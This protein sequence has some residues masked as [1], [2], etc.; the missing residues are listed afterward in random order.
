MLTIINSNTD[1]RFNLAVEEYVLKYLNLEEDF[2]LI[3][4]NDKS[5][6]IGRNQNPFIEINGA[7]VNKNHIP[8]IRR[9]TDRGAIYHDEGSIN[10]A[11]VTAST[12]KNNGNHQEFLDP[13]VTVLKGMGIDAHIKNK[14]NLFV[15]KD[16]ISIDYQNTYNDKIIHHGIIFVDSN[17]SY[18]KLVHNKKKINVVNVKKYFK[19]R[20]TVSM[21]RVLLLHELLEGEVAR[22]VY[23]LDKLDLKRINQLVEK[24]YNNWDWNYGESGEF[25]VKKEYDNRI[26]ITL[27]IKRGFIKDVSI[28]SFENPIKLEKA[29]LNIKYNEEEIR[30]AISSFTEIDTQEMIDTIMY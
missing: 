23:T 27:I 21:F 17:L 28:D 25:L 13:V 20:M 30:K 15:G 5:V 16:R 22:N 12:E 24:K 19:Q 6:I 14:R 18:M 4:Q 9:I 8:V 7:F 2:L 1:P 11:F 29:L 10:Y 3:W 26:Q